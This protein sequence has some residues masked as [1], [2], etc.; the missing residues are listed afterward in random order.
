MANDSGRG[1]FVW[2]DLRTTDQ[3]G[4]QAFY[5]AV[6]GWGTEVWNGMGLP[7]TMWT[8]GGRT[9]GGMMQLPP[10]ATARGTPAHWLA[11]IGTPNVDATSKQAVSL[12]AVLVMPPTAIAP[13]GKFSVL[14]DPAGAIFAMFTPEGNGLPEPA[15][16][17]VGHFSW[18]ELATR[19]VDAAFDFYQALFGWEK[20]R[21]MD[22]GA[23]GTYRLFRRD[24]A[25]LGGM[26]KISPQFNMPPSWTQYIHVADI[27][28]TAA[29]IPEH[30]GT[31]V[32]PPNDVP[33]HGRILMA[34]DPQGGFF[35]AHQP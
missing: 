22:M 11:Y 17:G 2:Y 19:D 5:T 1:R 29:S 18:H 3:A 31:V 21:D 14:R 28:A 23:M 4:A 30:G 24:G 33:G 16:P 26:Y 35:A 27:E 13:I 12:G 6:V 8:V 9:I 32:L 20:D 25:Q 34:S 15:A 7:Y 10:A